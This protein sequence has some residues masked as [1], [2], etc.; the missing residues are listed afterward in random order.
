MFVSGYRLT[1][2][3]RTLYESIAL[4]DGL[5]LL[6]RQ[7][8]SKISHCLFRLLW[9]KHVFR[10]LSLTVFLNGLFL[11]MNT[12]LKIPSQLRDTSG[13]PLYSLVMVRRYYTC[14]FRHRCLERQLKAGCRGL[15]SELVLLKKGRQNW[16]SEITLS[17]DPHKV[18]LS[19]SFRIVYLIFLI[20]GSFRAPYLNMLPPPS[21]MTLF[22]KD[23]SVIPAQAG[24][25]QSF[26]SPSCWGQTSA[27]V[28]N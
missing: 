22:S 23:P 11:S 12:S 1:R 28:T 15:Y 27:G 3:Y 21:L 4:I 6:L 25:Y 5:Q 2:F 19:Q 8:A 10:R 18:Y 13:F 7:R 9:V 17:F 20:M 14:S 16:Q 24:I 26:P